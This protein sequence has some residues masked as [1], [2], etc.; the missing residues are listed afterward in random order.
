MFAVL[1]FVGMLAL[2]TGLIHLYLWK[3]LVRDTLRPGRGR[4]IGGFLVLALALLVPATMIG[5]Q[6]GAYWLAWPGYVWLALMFYLLLLLL[7]LE[8]PMLLVR[9][10]SAARRGPAEPAPARVDGSAA[11]PALVGS[12]G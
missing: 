2:V 10:L 8:L 6:S 11:E 5:T 4:R 3:R 9:R 12:G 7:V 1:G